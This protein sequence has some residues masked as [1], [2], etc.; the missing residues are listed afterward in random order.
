[1]LRRDFVEPMLA[2]VE[3]RSP[4][5]GSALT[6]ARA[7]RYGPAA[8][9][10]LSAGDQVVAQLLRGIELYAKGQLNEAATQLQ[11]AAGPR[12]EF[13]PAAFFLGACF[14]AAG[15]DRD[16]AGVWQYAIGSEPRRTRCMRW[17]RM[18]GCATVRP[19]RPS[20]FSSFAYE[21]TPA[22]DLI[23]RRLAMAYVV[24]ARHADALPLLDT[25]LQRQPTDEEALFAAVL[26]QY[27]VVRAGQTLSSV[28]RAKMRRYAAAY[29]GTER[30]LVDKYLEV[31]QAR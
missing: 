27:E 9:E 8:L 14:A 12:R 3:K 10:A 24:M 5:L 19:G 29:R 1:V 4:T 6:E 25:Y 7:G 28:D 18:R 26:A 16:A 11:L 23:V 21:R 20:T 22:D 2:A 15:R 17:P 30:A 13:F 31:M